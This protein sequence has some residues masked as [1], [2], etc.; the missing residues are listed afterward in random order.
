MI[1]LALHELF[2]NA[3][4]YGALSAD[5]G[6]IEIA[7]GPAPDGVSQ[8]VWTDLDGPPVAPPARRG[9]GS[10]LIERALAGAIM[11]KVTLDFRPNG[12][13]C[14]IRGSFGSRQPTND[15]SEGRELQTPVLPSAVTRTGT[16]FAAGV[17]LSRSWWKS[18]M[19][20][21]NSG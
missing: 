20:P 7:C 10:Q 5:T 9:L 16:D 6:R 1:S 12:L 14:L 13:I 21:F 18:G 15:R 3:M 2:T 4:K 8:I 11:G 17:L 19:R